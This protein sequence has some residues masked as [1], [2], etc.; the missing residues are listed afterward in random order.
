MQRIR[1]QKGVAIVEFT[2]V[3]PLLLLLMLAIAEF[4]RA[5]Y[6]YNA[7]TKAVRDGARFMSENAFIGDSGQVSTVAPTE[8]K[9]LVAYGAIGAATCGAYG[10][11]CQDLPEFEWTHVNTPT[12]YQDAAG[13][14]YVTV[15]TLPSSDPDVYTYQPMLGNL[16]PL[17]S[18]AVN[19]PLQASTTMRVL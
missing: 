14:Y 11:V 2:I 9:R 17:T 3:L 7:L 13:D 5:L 19:I 10:G 6:Q 18:I 12:L 15:S 16:L 1:T 8:V 4:G